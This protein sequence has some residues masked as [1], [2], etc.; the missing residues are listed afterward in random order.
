MT[1]GNYTMAKADADAQFK[2]DNDAC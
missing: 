1:K 2:I